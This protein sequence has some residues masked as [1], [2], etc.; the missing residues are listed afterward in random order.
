[1]DKLF[2][3]FGRIRNKEDEIMNDKGV[4]LGLVLSNQLAYSIS[5]FKNKQGITV[6]SEYG[7]GSE[8]WFIAENMFDNPITSLIF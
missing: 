7:K 5:P 2:T 3:E 6:E 4:G 1:M 8:F